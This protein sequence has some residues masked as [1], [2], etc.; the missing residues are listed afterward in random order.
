MRTD[1]YKLRKCQVRLSWV[2]FVMR[3]RRRYMGNGVI[4]P[5]HNFRKL[6]RWCYRMHKVTKY[7]FIV[8][9]HGITIPNFIYFR[10]A[11]L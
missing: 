10:L 8:V 11:I 7:E 2:W 4:I 1:G 6:S 9:T 5:P 3:M